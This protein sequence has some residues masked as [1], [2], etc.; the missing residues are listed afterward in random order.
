MENFIILSNIGSASKKYSV[1]QGEIEVAWFHFEKVGENFLCSS[2]VYSVFEKK[3]ILEK[4]Y[5][6][7][8]IDVFESLQKSDAHIQTK[9]IDAIALRVVVPN[10]DFVLDM[11]CTEEVLNRLQDLQNIDPLHITPVLKEIQCS[12]DFF[13]KNTP[14]YFISDSSFHSTSSKKIPLSFEKQMYTIGYHGLSCESVLSF[15]KN[16]KINHHKLIIAHLGSGCSVTAVRDQTSLYNSMEVSPLDGVLMSSRSGSI[17]P[18]V[19]LLYMKEH[20]LTYDQTLEHLY[21]ESGLKN[22]SG[23]S[24]DLRIIREEAFKGNKEAKYAVNQFVDSVVSNICKATAF[25]Q[26]IETLVFTGTIGFRASYIREMVL[27]KLIWLG[28]VLDH[29]KNTDTS[30]VCFEISTH[31][32]KIKIIVIQTDEMKEMH[33]HTQKLLKTKV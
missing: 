32:S 9:D 13:E 6:N 3:H 18:F 27:E 1:Y 2:K 23:I 20:N 11:K 10:N 30:D 12:K 16:N 22:L 19:V 21:T 26:G 33:T 8:I 7:S 5:L 24:A 14:L 29:T 4:T 15:L 17:D 25:T 28:C 31:D